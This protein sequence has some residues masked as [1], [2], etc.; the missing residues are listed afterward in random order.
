LNQQLQQQATTII[1]LV[2]QVKGKSQV[3]INFDKAHDNLFSKAV[4][5]IKQP[6][7]AFFSWLITK[8]HI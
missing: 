1:T 5:V 8:T 6:L 7:E 4:S 2:K 3:L